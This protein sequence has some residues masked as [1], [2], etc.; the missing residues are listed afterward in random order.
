MDTSEKKPRL[1][2][3]GLAIAIALLLVIALILAALFCAFPWSMTVG[4]TLRP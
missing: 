2:P 4:R 3:S 1:R